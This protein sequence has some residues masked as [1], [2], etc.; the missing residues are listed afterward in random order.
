M[1]LSSERAAA[2]ATTLQRIRQIEQ[3]QGITR[4]SLQD[5]GMTAGWNDGF[6]LASPDG[7]FRMEVGGLVQFRYQ[8]SSSCG[9]QQRI[10]VKNF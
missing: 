2:V 7:R 8:L 9:E 3:E 5:S 4:A 1:S 10:L 6:F